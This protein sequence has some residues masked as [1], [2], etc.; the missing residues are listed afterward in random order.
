MEQ[1]IINRAGGGVLYL[2][3]YNK[4]SGVTDAE[5]VF[6]LQGAEEVNISV[7]SAETIPFEIGDTI[8]VFGRVYT[9][10]SLPPIEKNNDRQF[11]YTLK[12]EGIQYEL[13]K[14]QYLD[15][16][17]TLVSTGSTFDLMGNIETFLRVI[18]NNCDR[19]HGQGKFV[20]GEFPI[21]T[22]FEMQ[23]FQ[24]Q[25]CLDVLNSLCEKYS[26][27][28]FIERIGTTD[29]Y[30]IDVKKEDYIMPTT[31]E[32]G[33][34]RGLYKL[35]R[36]NI[37]DRNIVTRLFAFGG[38]QNI[39]PNYRGGSLNLKM[40]VVS[41]ASEG[42][43]Y[44]QDNFAVDKYGIIEAAVTFEDI[45]PQRTGEVTGVNP[46]NV[47]EFFD[48]TMNFNLS[49]SIGGVTTYLI[50]GMNAK[51]SFIEGSLA[52]YE[53]DVS[54]YD[55]NSKKFTINTYTDSN[56]QVFPDTAQPAFQISIGDKYKILNISMPQSYVN[57]AEG[58]LL[59][60]A[61]AYLNENNKPR[62]AYELEIDA[63]FIESA[64]NPTSIGNYFKVGDRVNVIDADLNIN[65][66]APIQSF[67]RNL[68]NHYDYVV[69]L[70][71]ESPNVAA[72]R[73]KAIRQRSLAIYGQVTYG[74]NSLTNQQVT[75]VTNIINTN[76][77]ASQNIQWIRQF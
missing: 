72:R 63:N 46:N 59:D 10:N 52:G 30:R 40:P 42:E 1:I 43:P 12:F 27:N 23:T 62:I 49:Q 19:I 17:E 34:A 26:M 38:T 11:V 55:H 25:N 68:L 71:E 16:D 54:D 77:P 31:F 41:I 28:Y 8:D 29:N 37:S 73:Y 69:Q 50:A 61:E 65:G 24:N 35:N 48:S 6:E 56:A 3:T 51:I 70:G 58:A 57:D 64:F 9:L 66:N 15:T 18:I 45:Y 7:T 4:V 33:R 21:D 44:I 75:Q 76:Q 22:F 20:L 2:N 39:P 36:R 53:F 67:T 60:R 13:I 47:L 74:N 32:Y 5:Q 14:I